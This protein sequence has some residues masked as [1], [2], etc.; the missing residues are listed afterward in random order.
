MPAATRILQ[1][2]GQASDDSDPFRAWQHVVDYPS[3]AMVF[4]E[5]Q[6]LRAA[7]REGRLPPGLEFKEAPDAAGVALCASSAMGRCV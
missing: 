6:N 3:S 1:M 4:S 5:T 7:S 2:V